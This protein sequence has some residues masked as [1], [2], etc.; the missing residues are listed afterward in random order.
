LFCRK[1]SNYVK[2]AAKFVLAVFYFIHLKTKN[3]NHPFIVIY[4]HGLKAAEIE[5]FKDQ[6]YYLSEK[7]RVIKPSMIRKIDHNGEKS[8][9][10][11][12]FDDAFEDIKDYVVPILKGY[13]LTAGIFVPVG[14]LG[15]PPHWEMLD[16]S[17]DRD[18]IVMNE[19]QILGLDKEGFE[20]LSHT[21]SHPVLTDIVD[22]ELNT[23]VCDSK[24]I[25]EDILGHEVTAISYPFGAFNSKV[26]KAAENAGYHTGFSIEPCPVNYSQDKFHI[27]RF[28]VLPT[29]GMTKFRLIINGG[30]GVLRHFRRL[31]NKHAKN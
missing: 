21:V 24:K 8:T 25:L 2:E 26:C 22:N 9:V 7:C 18:K 30:Y 4:Y 1:L 19:E 27:G 11:I 17:G 31:K 20:I 14:N 28:K 3:R 5:K 10:A 13:G 16:D 15:Q 6:M 23:E 29:D 12:T